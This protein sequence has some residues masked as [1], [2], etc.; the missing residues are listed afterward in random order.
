MLLN[1]YRKEFLADLRARASVA[2]NFTHNEFVDV[3]ANMLSDA[4]EISDFEACYYRG[5]GS[6][7][8]ALAI[9][10]LAQDDV[11]G[12]IRLV[13]AS[14]AGEEELQ[15][16][17]QQ[18]ARS[19]FARLTAFCEDSFSGRLLDEVDESS[20]AHSAALTLQQ[21]RKQVSRLRLYLITD[22]AL[23]TRVKD[24]P[25]G[26]IAGIQTEFHIWDINRFHQVSESKTGRDELTVDFTAIVP[27]GLP[28]LAASVD[29]ENYRAFLCV[30][31]GAALADIYQ[32]YGSRLLE[33]NVR[34]YLGTRGKINKMIRRT[35]AT[36]PTMFFAY[37]NGI[38]ATATKAI[39]QQQAD[40]LRLLQVTD[41]QIVNGGQTTATLASAFADKE[42]G[43]AQ[44]FVQMKLSEVTPET[45]GKYTPLIARYANSQNKVSDADFF[46]NHEFHQRMEQISH[47]LRAPAMNGAQ[48]G[49]HWRYERTRG[50]YMNEQSKLTP[51]QKNLFKLQNP[52]DQL[53]TKVDLA[54]FENAW[55]FLP[56]IVSQGAQ[57]NFMAFSTHA[58]AEWDRSPE[59][60]NEEFYKRVIIK[61]MLYWTTEDLVSKQSWY[62]N[63]YRANIVAYT[64]A[65]F[66]HLIQF[67]GTGNL[68]DFKACWARQ[69]LTPEI[70]AQLTAIAYEVFEVIVSPEGGF[71]NVT[72][73]AK[74]EICWQ[75]IQGLRIPL[76][77]GMAEQL[78]G[79]DEDRFLKK[80][81][82]SD[83]T[84]MSGIQ[85]QMTVV[86]LGGAYWQQL[87]SW[88]NKQLLLAPDEQ[89]LVSMACNMSKKV[90]T[91]KHSARLLQIKQKMENE[92][93]QLK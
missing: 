67:E 36:E 71:S 43:L 55:R 16:I 77:A 82:A 21:R 26:D 56:N 30:I 61:A 40:G 29:A 48:Y 42:S 11:D 64:V 62:Q 80:T 63:G 47:S 76:Q 25:E 13:I 39:V 22:S 6:K 70:E 53:I 15:T 14:F 5:T 3:C 52:P 83:Q 68:L 54:K 50:S 18:Q 59:Q 37:N 66:S 31:P 75:R 49:T 60:F 12:S 88:G 19:S 51:A 86:N 10:G 58:Q 85:T 45:N 44:A 28:C 46:S 38:S 4:E 8:R 34:S 92:G 9:D 89:S 74:K 1:D 90:P 27:G 7:N 69:G 20:P 24:W 91:E 93:F 81:A 33:G 84:V 72:E 79:R 73:W 17:T 41:L 87:L 57:K 35:V 78:V 32:Q 65:K 2:A 23:S